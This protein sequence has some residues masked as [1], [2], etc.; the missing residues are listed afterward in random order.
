M[1]K[2]PYREATVRSTVA[3]LKSIA[4]HST[5]D[6]PESVREYIAQSQVSDNRKGILVDAIARY[7]DF[8]HIPF[9][10][11]IYRKIQRLPFLPLEK[12]VDDLVI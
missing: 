11:P 7:Y 9:Q 10:R 2:K 4:R 6:D 3:C 12:E 8:R 5:L 1:R